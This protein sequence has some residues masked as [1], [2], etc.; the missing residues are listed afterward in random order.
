MAAAMD[1]FADDRLGGGGTGGSLSGGI[2]CCRQCYCWPPGY[3]LLL[4]FSENEEDRCYYYCCCC[5][6]KDKLRLI[7][8]CLILGWKREEREQSDV[9][10]FFKIR[11]TLSFVGTFGP[12]GGPFGSLSKFFLG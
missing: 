4:F 9:I 2:Y 1:I 5:C 3:L 10:K 12:S 8:R 6:F 11:G 7:H